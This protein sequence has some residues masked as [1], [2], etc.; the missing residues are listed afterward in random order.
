MAAC[1]N[2]TFTWTY[3]S[4]NQDCCTVASY[5]ASVCTGDPP[6]LDPALPAGYH[7]NAPSGSTATPCECNTVYYSVISACASCQNGQFLTWTQWHSNCSTAYTTFP[8]SLPSGTRVPHWAYLPIGADDNWNA[9]SAQAALSGPEST[10]TSSS[11][12]L[13]SSTTSTSATT[14]ATG[15]QKSKS[16]NV[17]AIAGG[18]VGGVVGLALVLLLGIFL[19]RRRNSNRV[20][21]SSLIDTSQYSGPTPLVGDKPNLG[22]NHTGSTMGTSFPAPSMNVSGAPMR[23]Y[24]PSDPTTFPS[25]MNT[26]AINGSDANLHA[27]GYHGG[28]EV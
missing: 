23:L 26:G 19:F 11:T 24:D 5:L 14:T 2:S 6:N 12:S 22:Y 18:V 27:R 8:E 7:Y 25:P 13:T 4:L 9:V 16:T 17:G 28:P 1:T 10:A 20:A 15:T 21:P 3:N